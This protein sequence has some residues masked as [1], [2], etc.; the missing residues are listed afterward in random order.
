MYQDPFKQVAMQDGLA[1]AFETRTPTVNDT[2][3]TTTNTAVMIRFISFT[4]FRFDIEASSTHSDNRP[5]RINSGRHGVTSSRIRLSC[6]RSN[7]FS[8]LIDY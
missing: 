3:N 7:P 4:S 6:C 5:G 8:G 2:A 1:S